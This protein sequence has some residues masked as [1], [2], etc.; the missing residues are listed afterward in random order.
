MLPSSSGGASPRTAERKCLSSPRY[1]SL[2]SNF[3]GESAQ[4]LLSG[5]YV[6]RVMEGMS[7]TMVPLLQAILLSFTATLPTEAQGTLGLM[8][9]RNVLAD[10]ELQAAMVNSLV[11][12]SL[13][14]AL[15]ISIGL[16]AAYALALR[17]PRRAGV[18]FEPEQVRLANGDGVPRPAGVQDTAS[19]FVQLTWLFTTQPQRLRV[20]EAV[21]MPLALPRRVDLWMYDVVQAE[22]LWM[23][24][25]EIDTWHVK[26]RRP[27]RPGGELTAEVWIAPSLQYLPVRIVIRQDA[28]TF[29]DLLLT[30]LPQ[31][32]GD[33]ARR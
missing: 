32:D 20:G 33:P 22:R 13:N 28:D 9:Y 23:P 17:S 24:V 10:P 3:F 11:Y 18:A 4:V 30:R 21:E 27:A 12:V 7:Q 16:P 6:F 1:V 8:N 2:K 29:V 14:F 31:Q 25:G 15:C 19:Q 26:P 5:E